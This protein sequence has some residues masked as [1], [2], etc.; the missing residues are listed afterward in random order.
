MR[1]AVH[2]ACA[3][4]IINQNSPDHR[5]RRQQMERPV[6]DETDASDADRQGRF[7]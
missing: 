5:I 6:S 2:K 4:G 7:P 3:G 1:A